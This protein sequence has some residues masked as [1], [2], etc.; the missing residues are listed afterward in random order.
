MAGPAE[1]TAIGN[2]LAQAMANGWIGSA[3]EMIDVV[4]KSFPTEEYAPGGDGAWDDA[5]ARFQGFAGG[6][7][8]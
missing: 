6:E 4:A 7:G 1:A 8:S 5:F 2:L 3:A